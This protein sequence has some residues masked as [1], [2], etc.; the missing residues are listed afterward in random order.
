MRISFLIAIL[1]TAKF[2][3]AQQLSPVKVEEGVVQGTFED[4]LTVYKG[5]P[6]ATPPVGDLRWR[7]PQPAAKWE[8]VF[9][10]DAFGPSCTPGGAAGGRGRGGAPG[11]A[12][13]R[14]N[15]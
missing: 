2:V 4:G 9:K 15:A 1:I 6:F 3:T 13:G 7:A 12:P 10:A 11:A 14:G 8:G 5:I